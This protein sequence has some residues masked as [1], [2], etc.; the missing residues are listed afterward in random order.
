MER[1]RYIIIALL[2]SL[3][4]NLR[5]Q[6][7]DVV[8]KNVSVGYNPATN[9]VTVD[10]RIVAG[11]KAVKS[12]YSLVISPFI[13][14]AQQLS[15]PAVVI[16][17]H[18]ARISR[19]R[20]LRSNSAATADKIYITNGDIH[21][22]HLSAPYADWMQGASLR[23][24][25]QLEGCCSVSLPRIYQ[26]SGHLA[27]E[28][29]KPQPVVQPSGDLHHTIVQPV[30]DIGR[31]L[32]NGSASQWDIQR[33]IDE[34]RDGSIVIYFRQGSRVVDV[35]YMDNYNRI[36]WLTA[37]IREIENSGDR[38]VKGVIVMGFSSPEGTAA[39]NDRLAGER[40]SVIRD[41]ILSNTSLRYDDVRLYNGGVDWGRL[42]EL[43]K[44]AIGMPDQWRVLDIIDRVP[45]WDAQR[46][47]GRL[48][49]LMRLSGG[50]PYRFMLRELFPKMR[51]AAY[52]RL[53]YDNK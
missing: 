43:V 21:D 27:F 14:G 23:V 49:E 47:T 9:E 1:I 44:S 50:A 15:F 46:Q 34:S 5:S 2:C 37:A 28:Q 6:T 33:S 32:L 4:L 24:S 53:Y 25:N 39:I 52:I 48:S 42:R 16:E 13:E 45:L 11:H 31:R 20:Q 22:Y 19:V 10:F 26:L 36:A 18:R 51:H 35:N 7:P 3:T 41:Y 38:Q 12:D 40:A 17:G 30:T 29:E 8:Y